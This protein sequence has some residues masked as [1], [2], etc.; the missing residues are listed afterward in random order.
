M[1]E[2]LT[3]TQRVIA[4]AIIVIGLGVLAYFAM[5][6]E[7]APSKQIGDVQQQSNQQGE[8][9]ESNNTISF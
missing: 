3:G 9:N 4:I 2:G 6:G 8:N 1:L 5:P 7:E